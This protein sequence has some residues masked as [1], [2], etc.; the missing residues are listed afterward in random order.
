MTHGDGGSPTQNELGTEGSSGRL[1]ELARDPYG[2][3]YV[4]EGG[5][6]Q[7][8]G[9]SPAGSGAKGQAEGSSRGAGAEAQVTRP[10]PPS[11]SSRAGAGAGSGRVSPPPPRCL[12]FSGRRRGSA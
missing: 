12:H 6:T 2:C 1:D 9:A 3:L 10:G 7:R 5:G 4:C 8:A 11:R